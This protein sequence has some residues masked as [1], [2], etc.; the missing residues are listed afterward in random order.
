MRRRRGPDFFAAYER[1][2]APAR[3]GRVDIV[4]HGGDVLFRSRVPAALAQRAYAPLLELADRGLPVFVVPGNH[5]RSRLPYPLLL[6]HPLVHVFDRPRTHL[7]RVGGCAS[8]SL[9]FRSRATSE[10]RRCAFSSN[11]RSG[12][13]TAPTCG[14]SA[15][16]KRSRGR[17]WAFRTTLFAQARTSSRASRFRLLSPPSSRGTSTAP[18][19]WTRAGRRR[20]SIPGRPSARPSRSA[21]RRRGVCSSHSQ[22]AVWSTGPS[23][24]CPRA[25]WKW[26]SWTRVDCA[27]RR[28]AIGCANSS[29]PST[30]RPWCAWTS[31]GSVC[32]GPSGPTPCAAWPRRA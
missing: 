18:R 13:P 23:C 4:V 6:S 5:E 7:C 12:A 27:S 25:R 26:R 8:R 2:L 30:P 16:I 3:E 14:S 1:A 17:K 9:V 32:R 20:C 24:L 10:T 22:W 21:K 31:R 29:A 19:C 15:S 28:C 11:G